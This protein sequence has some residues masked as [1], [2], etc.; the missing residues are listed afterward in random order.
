MNK[1]LCI[2]GK[3]IGQKDT[4]LKIFLNLEED[5]NT[6]RMGDIRSWSDIGSSM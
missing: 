4:L 2:T 5:H 3:K 1:T 6:E